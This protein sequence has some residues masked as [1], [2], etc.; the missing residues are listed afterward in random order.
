MQRLSVKRLPI[1]PPEEINMHISKSVKITS[2]Y[3]KYLSWLTSNTFHHNNAE[4]YFMWTQYHT[5]LPNNVL[6][7]FIIF[8]PEMIQQ[9]YDS[10]YIRIDKVEYEPKLYLSPVLHTTQPNRDQG[11][12]AS[13]LVSIRKRN[14]D[15]PVIHL[16]RPPDIINDIVDI[17]FD[18]Y[19]D[20]HKLNGAIQSLNYNSRVH[21]IEWFHSRDDSQKKAL[22]TYGH[23]LTTENDYAKYAGTGQYVTNVLRACMK[24]HWFI[25]DGLRSEALNGAVNKILMN[26]DEYIPQEIDFGKFDKSQEEI[27]LLVLVKILKRLNVDSWTLND[28]IDCHT[29]NT[30]TYHKVGISDRTKYQ[31]RSGDVLTFIGN[32]ILL[33]A[34]LAYTHDYKSAIGGIFGCDDSIVFLNK[35]H[36][37]VDK[38]QQIA[39]VFNLI[40]KLDN[41]A[42]APYFSG[43]FLIY[44]DGNYYLIPDPVKI[45][46]R[47]GRSDCYCKEHAEL[48]WM[49]F[50][51]NYKCYRDLDIRTNVCIAAA[52]RYNKVSK[53]KIN[54]LTGFGDFICNLVVN[55]QNFIKLF[56][57][58]SDI[59]NRPLPKA[60]KEE[61]LRKQSRQRGVQIDH[62]DETDLFEDM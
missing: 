12:L 37:I 41:F 44:S 54:D 62:F 8:N 51:D 40:A 28:W 59:L 21:T 30:L 14:L 9:L 29:L 52:N 11:D 34:A 57:G 18:T 47:L 17:F 32:T 60:I 19:I 1:F 3:D 31:R 16:T 5:K 23:I 13:A 35:N 39:D 56:N 55:K 26:C 53:T 46:T 38:S 15:P 20:H 43:K 27:C 49:S 61:I 2:I 22:L 48:A 10:I 24:D 58:P 7:D 33:M 6:C 4:T 45:I 42:T 36:A 25:N 50:S